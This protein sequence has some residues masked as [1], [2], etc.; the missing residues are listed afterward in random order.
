MVGPVSRVRARLTNGFPCGGLDRP[1][2][3]KSVRQ[4]GIGHLGTTLGDGG[5]ASR[6]PRSVVSRPAVA[7]AGISVSAGLLPITH[8]TSLG[9]GR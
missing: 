9:G 1:R 3:S 2:G 5:R 8:R 4:Y 7:R 6:L